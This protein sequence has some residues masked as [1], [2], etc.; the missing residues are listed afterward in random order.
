[1]CRNIRT[2]FDFEPPASELEIRQ[3]ALQCVRKP[4]NKVA[5]CCANGIVPR[6]Q[7]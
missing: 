7:C 1:M 4:L 3:A 6:A 5:S 2:L